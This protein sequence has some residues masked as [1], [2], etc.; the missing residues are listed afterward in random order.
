MAS[1]TMARSAPLKLTT[2][3]TMT[4]VDAAVGHGIDY[5]DDADAANAG[6]DDDNDGK[7]DEDDVHEYNIAV[8]EYADYCD[9]DGDADAA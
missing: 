4:Y 5:A 3:L 7:S 6:A 8:V 2:V 9:D 1:T